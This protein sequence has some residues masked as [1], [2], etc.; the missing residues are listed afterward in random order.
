MI[1]L[2][3][4]NLQLFESP[5]YKIISV[6]ESLKIMSDWSMYQYDSE[7]NG[8]DCHVN[9]LLCVQFGN[10]EGT[11]QIV[12][13][14]TTTNILYYKE[15]IESHYMIGQNLK[16]DLQF[17]FNY[18]I[19]PRKVYDT[20][21]TEQ[22][23][24]LGFPYTIV[25]PSFYKENNFDFPYKLI[26]DD[27]SSMVTGYELSYSLWAIAYK[28]LKIDIDKSIRGEII[29]RGL[30]T[31]VIKYAAGDVTYLGHIMKYQLQ[32]CKKKKCVIAAK[33]EC[34]FVPV[35][36]YMEWCGIKLDE[37]RWKAKMEN[38]LKNLEEAKKALDEFVIKTP[39]L[40]HFTY[41]ERQGSLFDGFDLAPKVSINWSS[42]SQVVKVAKILGFNTTVQDKKSGEDK[43]SVIEKHLKKQKGINDEFL[44]LYFGKGEEG[45]EDYFAGYQGSAKVVT[46]FGQGH[47]N[48]INPKTGRIHTQYKQL[49]ADTGRMSCGSTNPNTDLAKFKKLPQGS[50]KYPNMQQLPHDAVT[51]SCFVAGEGN[52]WVSCDYAAIE[53]R[54]G[55]AIYEEKSIIDEF[56]HGS[57]DMHSLVAK[58]VFKELADVPVKEI[59]KRFPHLRNAAKPIEFSQQFGG[60]AFAI[61]NAMGCTI[62]EA[63]AFADAY[64]EGFKGI[65][66][67]KAKGSSY[68]RKYGHIVLCPIT[69][70]KTYWWDHNVWTARQQTYTQE[71]WEDYR[72]NH[73]G[74][75]DSIALEVKTHFQAASKWDRKALNSVTQGTGA[76][77]LKDSQI[78]LFNWVV[79]NGYFGKIRLC[80]LTHDE[81][82][83]EFPKELEDT[84]PKFLQ[85]TMEKS[86]YKYCKALPIPA[87]A[88][89]GEC[90]IH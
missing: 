39:S 7:T 50:C 81:A 70:H 74:T 40:Q 44:R 52:L 83:W 76:I 36:S 77:I 56:L 5:E 17:L 29:W 80:N 12:V 4:G 84:F 64:A 45:D 68:V 41:V 54:L 23:L 9:D 47:L 48:C 14:T 58:M 38:D 85:D 59:K 61:Q 3:T 22:V 62:E 53:S 82:N 67:F 2:V 31:S 15:Y 71:F 46:S 16:F 37:A 57:G 51:R 8:R 43:E 1:Y 30:D 55:G 79:D 86:A 73:K 26:R 72:N 19:V 11:I 87:E 69:G 13:D 6:E 20:M 32:E 18:G 88:S 24:Y 21:I 66:K 60:S 25:S 42:S 63:Q 78:D 90:W 89:V 35:I 65:A 27:V 34:D 28:Y 33:L 75:G 49:G 10:M